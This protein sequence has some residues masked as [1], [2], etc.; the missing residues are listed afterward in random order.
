MRAFVAID[1]PAA[2][3]D[4]L[5]LVQ[6]AIPCGRLVPADNLHLTLAFLGEVDT[7]ALSVLH[8]HLTGVAAAPLD[9]TLAGLDLFGGRAPA[10]LFI[11]ARGAGLTALHDKVRSAAR[12]AGLQLERRRFRPHVTL[13]RFKPG[14]GRGDQARLGRFLEGQADFALPPVPVDHFSLYRSTLRPDGARHEA[15]ATYPLNG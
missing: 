4:A 10:V 11:Q 1:L 7:A 2:V 12:A 8:E 15:L 3:V 14:M 6:A 9:L 13:A 5:E